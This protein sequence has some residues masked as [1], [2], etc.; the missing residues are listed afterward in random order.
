MMKKAV[1]FLLFI[2]SCTLR[3]SAQDD[4][5]GTTTKLPPRQGFVIG[6][7][8][9]FDM[10]AASMADRFGLSYR[11][12]PSVFYKTKSNWVFGTKVDFML[13]NKIK[14]DS[15]LSNIMDDYG[16]IV[17]RDGKRSTVR[18][19]ELGYIIGLQAGYIFNTS[20][21]NSDNGIML[22]TTL[23]FMQHKINIFQQANTIPQIRGDY[24]KGYDRLTNGLLLEQYVGYNYFANNGL[25][26]FHI[27]LDIAAGFTKGRRDYLYDV[28]RPDD[29][30]RLDILFGV[31]GGWYIPIFKRKSEEF[32]FE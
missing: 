25:L 1:Y 3:V 13:G 21:K 27:G 8:G 7:N 2:L 32:Y 9:N 29:A 11:V 22:L 16:T 19:T 17:D 4:L 24:R 30:S 28:R 15:L 12:G 14:E 10:P 31:R 6:V 18:I 20:K 23:G 26:N 5:F